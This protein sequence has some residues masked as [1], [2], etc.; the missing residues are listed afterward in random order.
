M[1][2]VKEGVLALLSPT[3]TDPIHS[4][5]GLQAALLDPKRAKRILANRQSAAR[6]KE[7][8]MRYIS[9][10]ERRVALLQGEAS[11]LTSQSQVHWL[12]QSHCK[13]RRRGEPRKLLGRGG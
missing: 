2:C 12:A 11:S 10:L 1:Y 3:P 4:Q 13:L 7:R 6:S 5:T 9:E 8:K